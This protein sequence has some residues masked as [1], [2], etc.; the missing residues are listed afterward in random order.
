MPSNFDPLEMVETLAR[1]FALEAKE[2]QSQLVSF[3]TPE[4]PSALVGDRKKISQLLSMLTENALKS[5]THMHAGAVVIEAILD[6]DLNKESMRF[7]VSDSRTTLTP[8]Q[9]KSMN[10]ELMNL[11]IG[12]CTAAQLLAELD[13]KF[14]VDLELLGRSTRFYFSMPLERGKVDIAEPPLPKDLRDLKVFLV[15]NDPAPNRII[16]HYC[17][18]AGFDID[19]APTAAE[20]IIE[21]GR[22]GAVDILAVAPPIEDLSAIQ[23]AQTIR[24]SALA[25]TRLLYIA[26]WHDAEDV[27]AHKNAGFDEIITKPFTKKEL[28]DSIERLAGRISRKALKAPLVL[29]AEDNPINAQIASFQLRKIGYDADLVTNGKEA[30]EALEA[31]EYVAVLMDL[32]MPVMDG[33]E[34]TRL[35]RA[36]EEAKRKKHIPIIVLTANAD[37]RDLAE[38]AGCDLFLTKPTRIGELQSALTRCLAS[39]EQPSMG[40]FT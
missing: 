29:V 36:S 20:T 14:Q 6:K 12:N 13:A 40:Q 39:F 18:H 28:F 2:R 15:A 22:G 16:P 37:M 1:D 23:L 27:L 4:L 21:L 7:G 38:S 34:A 3:C 24:S 33:L 32:Q 5:V 35:I 26:P 9:A 17:R 25:G 11:K 10:C 19:G 30:V 8:E 31:G